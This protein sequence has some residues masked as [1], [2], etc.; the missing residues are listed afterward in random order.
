MEQIRAALPFKS[1]PSQIRSTVLL[2]YQLGKISQTALGLYVE[3]LALPELTRD[4][5]LPWSHY[6][7][8]TGGPRSPEA[9]AFYHS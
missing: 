3:L 1:D 5:P 2:E 8:L 7:L 4:F 6:V 9:I